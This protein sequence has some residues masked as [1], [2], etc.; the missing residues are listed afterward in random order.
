[1]AD[2]RILIDWQRAHYDNVV[3]D[4]GHDDKPG[5]L[6]NSAAVAVS[7]MTMVWQIISAV[8]RI[9]LTDNASMSA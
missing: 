1:M 4:S 2:M 9:S 6:E 5:R 3:H 7:V 8:L